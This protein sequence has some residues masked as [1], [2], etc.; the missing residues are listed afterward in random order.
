MGIR[1]FGKWQEEWVLH[2]RGEKPEEVVEINKIRKQLMEILTPFTE[3][4][5]TRKGTVL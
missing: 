4:M 3:Q 2:Y 1:G 5:K